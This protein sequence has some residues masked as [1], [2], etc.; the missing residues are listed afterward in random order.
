ML[1]KRR[2]K[3]SLVTFRPPPAPHIDVL[4]RFGLVVALVLAA[5]SCE[6]SLAGFGNTPVDALRNASDG[7][8]S[9]ALRFDDVVRD[10][11]TT[12]AR[13]KLSRYALTPSRIYDDSSV[14]NAMGERDSSRTLTLDGSYDAVRGGYNFSANA[15]ATP[16]NALA[17]ARHVVRLE[18][19]PD[20][21]Y[22][23]DTSVDHA[24]GGLPAAS[25]GRALTMLF[26]S[27]E[28]SEARDLRNESAQA[29]PRSARALGRLFALDSA[30]STAMADGSSSTTVGLRWQSQRLRGMPNFKSY[31]AKYIE[32]STYRVTLSDE[33]GQ[34]YFH[35]LG[36]KGQMLVRWRSRAGRL[37]PLGG[38]SSAMPDTLRIRLDFT[39][40][41][42]MFRV[43]FTEMVGDFFVQRGPHVS[44]WLMR[45]RQE[46]KWQLPLFTETLIRTPLRRPFQGRG[47]E[48]YLAV[49]DGGAQ[50][51]LV[52]RSHTEVKESAILRWLGGL[53]AT[54]MGDFQGRAEAEQNLFLM[55]AFAALRADAQHALVSGNGGKDS[56]TTR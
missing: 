13:A 33:R 29:F 51:L 11:K 35:V 54:A 16:P 5:T 8:T 42:K 20:G 22:F 3:E 40:K 15:R 12:E 1:L 9:H 24:I 45:F 25:A 41:Y 39:A 34:T 32:P 2:K 55:A 23:W 18:L 27:T 48:L 31:I 10:T 17:D 30:R 26:A 6:S 7:F 36:E 19:R 56:S 14:W 38:G 44:G 47:S 21:A 28:A 43:G 46:P 50:T 49:H 37:L 53:G 52:R 4:H